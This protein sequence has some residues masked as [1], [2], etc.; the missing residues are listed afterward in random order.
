MTSGPWG[1]RDTAKKGGDRVS[2]ADGASPTFDLERIEQF[3]F[4]YDA[5]AP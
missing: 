2:Q 1:S 3:K 5:I 4:H